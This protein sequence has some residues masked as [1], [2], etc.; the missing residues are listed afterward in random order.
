MYFSITF[1]EFLLF[2]SRDG[3]GLTNASD[4]DR[5]GFLLS[6]SIC[7]WGSRLLCL[8]KKSKSSGFS[9][10]NFSKFVDCFFNPIV[11]LPLVLF[12]L[13]FEFLL[14]DGD[15]ALDPSLFADSIGRNKVSSK[16]LLVFLLINKNYNLLD[17]NFIFYS[18]LFQLVI[19]S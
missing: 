9:V 4:H 16:L 10:I 7:C 1:A 19:L 18:V 6:F 11:I 13:C 3:F 15:D 5:G 12:L 17:L 8:F 14:N 2:P